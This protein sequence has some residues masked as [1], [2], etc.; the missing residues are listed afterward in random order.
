MR[1]SGAGFKTTSTTL[2][3]WILAMVAF[4]EVQFRSHAGLDAMV[5]CARLPIYADAPRL[6]Y[7]RA[8]VNEVLRWRPAGRLEVPH[9]MAIEG[10]YD[11][12]FIPKGVTCIA[13]IWH[14]NHDRVFGN[15]ADDSRPE[16]SPRDS[17]ELI[18]SRKETSSEG[19]SVVRI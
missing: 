9:V 3:W 7:V 1:R 11:G 14:C 16:R 15:D 10:W 12:I 13:N 4:P 6:P 2:L 5:G 19:S 8:I 17:C 18:P